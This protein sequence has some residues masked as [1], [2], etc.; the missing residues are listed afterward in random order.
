MTCW[1]AKSVASKT[2]TGYSVTV[3]YANYQCKEPL[4]GLSVHCQSSVT[5]TNTFQRRTG[6]WFNNYGNQTPSCSE[7]CIFSASFP[8]PLF[9]VVNDLQIL[10]WQF[11]KQCVF[12]LPCPLLMIQQRKLHRDLRK[13][14]SQGQAGKR[15]LVDDILTLQTLLLLTGRATLPTFINTLGGGLTGNIL[16][17]HV[18][19]SHGITIKYTHCTALH[20]TTLHYTTPA[21]YSSS[22]LA[23]PCLHICNNHRNHIQFIGQH[24]TQQCVLVWRTKMPTLN[25]HNRISGEK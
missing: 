11:I 15:E 18:M 6:N 9:V 23:C 12:H 22:C 21:N 16:P 2:H 13:F 4:T 19:S 14:A 25:R 8:S 20:Y 1:P 7:S 17:Y 5:T 24:S 10:M 3:K